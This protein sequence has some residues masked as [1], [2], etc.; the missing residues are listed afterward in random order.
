[1]VRYRL[2][3]LGWF[4][5]EALAQ[6][7]LK[8]DLG[9][10]V[11][12]WGGRGDHGRDA[13]FSGALNFPSKSIRSDGPFIFQVKFVSE[14]NAAGA[15]PEASLL[16]AVRKEMGLIAER[17][18]RLKGVRPS[19]YVL[20]TNSPVSARS[21][22]KVEALLSKALSG[23]DSHCLGAGDVCDLLD[24][25]SELRRA[26][27]QLLSLRDLDVLIAEAVSRE[28]LERSRSAVEGA[29][30]VAPTFVPTSAY[31]RAWE[32]LRRHHFAVLEGPPEVGKTAIAWMIALTQLSLGWQAVVCDDPADLFQRYSRETRQVFVADDAFGR[33]EYDPSRGS[34]WESQ[35]SRVYRELDGSHWLV[36]TSRH[37]I[38]ERAKRAMDLQGEAQGFPRPGAVLV[39]A[40]ELSQ[41]EKALMLY[42]HARG[43]G[44]EVEAKE[45]LRRHVRSVVGDPDFTPERIRRFVTT[46]LPGLARENSRRRIKD[47]EIAER[48]RESI[49][50]ATDRIL[51]T[52]SKLPA[53][54]KW[55]LVSLLESGGASDVAAVESAY[56][57]HCPAAD[58]GDYTFSVILD[59]LTEAF[60]KR[61]SSL[62]ARRERVDWIHPSYRDVVIDQ[63]AADPGMQLSFVENS[64]LPG[65]KLA[66]SEAGG[67]KGNRRFP[68][69]SAPGSW[70]ALRRSCTAVAKGDADWA[71]V[72]LCETLHHAFLTAPDAKSKDEVLATIKSVLP[73]VREGWDERRVALGSYALS[74]YCNLSALVSPLPPLPNLLPSIEAKHARLL[75][76]LDGAEGH[77]E[78]DQTAVSEWVD[79]IEIVRENEP[80]VLR[81][82]GFPEKQLSDVTRLVESAKSELAGEPDYDSSELYN[83]ES[84][85]VES[86]G[87]ALA[88]LSSI[89]PS[90][91]EELSVLASK[92]ESKASMYRGRAEEMEERAAAEEDWGDPQKID[93]PRGEL[94]DVDGLFSDL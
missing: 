66:L 2:D 44:L 83:E 45:L 38:L 23:C 46:D 1:M 89:I 62:W 74:A 86:I 14:A 47:D 67:A 15:K 81:Q 59:E 72:E 12:S 78:L 19:H 77:Y 54:H 21:R 75:E 8:A 87:E 56:A 34:K 64:G 11:E 5:F 48:I 63:L 24:A 55:V 6:A 65:I 27:P 60:V 57:M 16:A 35:L 43:A 32:C 18:L 51:K 84:S 31:R 52:Y 9:L 61:V 88:K 49:R 80:R 85:R 3:D 94:L 58:R 68:L 41:E 30:M 71:G 33:T 20:V 93:R 17:Q 26:F 90:E 79:L 69:L 91:A 25:H 29:R 40:T 10:G 82:L 4:Q 39:D 42:R 76:A 50:N 92:L 53:G 22:E 7:L 13:F 37:H 73:L 70:D 36:W 28:N